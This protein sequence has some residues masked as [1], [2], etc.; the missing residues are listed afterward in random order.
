MYVFVHLVFSHWIQNPPGNRQEGLT[1]NP[2][3]NMRLT[4]DA[5][6]LAGTPWGL[7]RRLYAVVAEASGLTENGNIKDTFYH[8]ERKTNSL[9]QLTEAIDN[10]MRKRRLEGNQ[11]NDL[12]K[13]NTTWTNTLN[14]LIPTKLL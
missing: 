7:R 13:M 4:N 14:F 3:G 10:E 12:K 11:W 2:I 9:E 8:S 1:N 5:V 6:I